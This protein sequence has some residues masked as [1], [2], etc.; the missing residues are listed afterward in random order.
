MFGGE[1]SGVGRKVW[2]CPWAAGLLAG[3]WARLLAPGGEG[4]LGLRRRH[5]HILEPACA[6]P[7]LLFL[8]PRFQQVL[9]GHHHFS[10]A[11]GACSCSFSLR[12]MTFTIPELC[13]PSSPGSEIWKSREKNASMKQEGPPLPLLQGQEPVTAGCL[14]Q[15]GWPCCGALDRELGSNLSSATGQGCDMGQVT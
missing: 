11:T 3:A 10:L 9:R 5:L 15:R 14:Y 1:T 2:P 12:V 4:G 13:R 6:L 8:L 7:G